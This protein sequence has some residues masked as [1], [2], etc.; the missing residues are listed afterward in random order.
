MRTLRLIGR[1]LS[2]TLEHLLPFTLLTLAWWLA[3]LTVV[4]A[5]GATVAL[6]AMTDPR[7]AV[8]RPEWREAVA[9]TRANLRRGWA[10]ALFA[11]VPLA[12]LLSNLVAYGGADSRWQILVPLWIYLLVFGVVAVLYAVAVVALTGSGSRAA[13]RAAL[14]LLALAP[15]RAAVVALVVGVIVLVGAALVVPLVMFVPA[16]VAALV[17]RVVLAGLGI[18]VADPLAPTDERAAEEQR[19]AGTSRFGP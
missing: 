4:A 8:S 17:N 3:V 11:A 7:L 14:S 6:F 5:P 10:L 16:L 19:A 2:D 9:A 18:V 15:L 12:L 13:A 1:G